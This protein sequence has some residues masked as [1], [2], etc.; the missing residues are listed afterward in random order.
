MKKFLLILL[1]SPLLF[2]CGE[3]DFEPVIA[4]IDDG[5]FT[6]N[7][8]PGYPYGSEETWL[9]IHDLEGKPIH[10]TPVAQGSSNK[11]DLDREARYHVTIF[12]NNSSTGSKS[13]IL[14]SFTNIQATRDLTLGINSRSGTAVVTKGIF[15]V[16]IAMEDVGYSAYVSSIHNT[17][18]VA[19]NTQDLEL[20]MITPFY[21]NE[22]K[23]LVAARDKLG[24]NRYTYVSPSSNET[25]YNFDFNS[26]NTYDK[27][28]K[29]SNP[30][31][32]DVYFSVNAL[33][34]QGNIY[35]PT[36]LVSSNQ[37]GGPSTEIAYLNEFEA[38]ST[39]INS[40][41][42]DLPLTDKGFYKIG[43][44]PEKIE[45]LNES[46]IDVQTN[47][48]TD[49]S[50]SMFPDATDYSVTFNYPDLYNYPDP[51]IIVTWKVS[52]DQPTFKLDLPSE[53]KN[54]YFNL[55]DLSKLQLESI[56][57]NKSSISYDQF[58]VD[59][60]VETPVLKKIEVSYIKQFYPK[61]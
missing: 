36:Y 32:S 60:L 49:F 46:E 23:Y 41:T 58:I 44:I 13:T 38:Y 2:A 28:I 15:N 31:S 59:E 5:L 47:K 35:V 50:M 29:I 61:N 25:S 51:L 8:T 52:G 55:S 20:E 27:I 3:D 39:V 26:L 48:L 53:I 17:N 18:Q 30:E 9:I 42:K 11:F 16:N 40:Y 7:L 14:Q 34:E 1:F 6:I 10:F 21:P 4:Q 24:Q 19:T 56:T 57:M 43:G 22:N 37:F 33:K 12:T 54:L 45:F